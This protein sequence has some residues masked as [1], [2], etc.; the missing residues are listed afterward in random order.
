MD[1]AAGWM[2]FATPPVSAARAQPRRCL[3]FADR[4]DAS[5]GDRAPEPLPGCCARRSTRAN[6][7]NFQSL[8]RRYASGGQLMPT[9]TLSGGYRTGL[10]ATFRTDR[11]WVEPLWT[12]VG[13]AL[14]VI[15]SNWA[16]FQG[17]YYW[18][19]SYLSP[20]Y[21]P[22]LFVDPSAPGAAPL[23]HAWIGAWP[24]W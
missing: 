16:A 24:Q 1:W 17:A 6:T 23:H 18:Y 12:G 2:R 11:W 14:F 5:Y 20:F 10:A 4:S 22:L 9:S 21:S 19:G 8:S 15:Y 3:P 13:F 7:P